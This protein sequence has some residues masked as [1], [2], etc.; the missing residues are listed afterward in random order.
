MSSI[1]NIRLMRL[2]QTEGHIRSIIK[3]ESPYG[4]VET[5]FQRFFVIV[6]IY[7]MK[8]RVED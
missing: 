1:M 8:R 6:L 4:F 5:T 3:Q 7:G 2:P